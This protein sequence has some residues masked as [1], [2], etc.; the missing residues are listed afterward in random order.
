MK[1]TVKLVVQTARADLEFALKLISDRNTTLFTRTHKHN[2]VYRIEAVSW[3]LGYGVNAREPKHDRRGQ[4]FSI[5][6][7]RASHGWGCGTSGPLLV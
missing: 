1:L 5:L 3:S 7:P 2:R 4:P 6:L